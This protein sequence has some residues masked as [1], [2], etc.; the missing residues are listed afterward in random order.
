[1]R[2]FE[3]F[4]PQCVWNCT[5]VRL[6][7][8]SRLDISLHS[9]WEDERK[10]R[11]AKAFFFL[12]IFLLS[13]QVSSLGDK[14]FNLAER[15]YLK[16]ELEGPH[17]WQVARLKSSWRYRNILPFF[18]RWWLPNHRWTTVNVRYLQQHQLKIQ[19]VNMVSEKRDHF[20]LS[21]CRRD[22]FLSCKDFVITV[23]LRSSK[24]R[25]KLLG[26][27][28][29][30]NCCQTLMIQFSI[31][32]LGLILVM[33]WHGRSST[34]GK[35]KRNKQKYSFRLSLKV[36]WGLRGNK[37]EELEGK[38][39]GSTVIKRENQFSRVPPTQRPAGQ[40]EK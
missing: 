16:H 32:N 22:N 17:S 21:I 38:R 24:D 36:P 40:T 15:I 28:G 6:Q 33:T 30:P 29:Q 8:F 19:S 7:Y 14:T 34:T 5:M 23:Y 31:V 2:L 27:N 11:I 10:R 20:L 12:H 9:C 1:M 37:S 4:S 35:R 26:G 18:S 3:L 25:G 39:N 13:C